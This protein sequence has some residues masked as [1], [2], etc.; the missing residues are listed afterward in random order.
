M[1][2]IAALDHLAGFVLHHLVLDAD[3]GERSPHHHF[4]VAAAGA[5]LVEVDDADLMV[6]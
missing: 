3:V 5:V 4:M 2:G 6:A 1:N